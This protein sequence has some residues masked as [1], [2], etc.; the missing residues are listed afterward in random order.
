MI[1]PMMSAGITR[2]NQSTA[3]STLSHSGGAMNPQACENQAPPRI[4]ETMLMKSGMATKTPRRTAVTITPADA[5]PR[6]TSSTWMRPEKSGSSS[7]PIR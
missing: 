3:R 6:M 4:P 7:Q 1:A 5:R 2:P